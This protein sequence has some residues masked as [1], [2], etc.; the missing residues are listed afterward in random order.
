[1]ATC[2]GRKKDGTPCGSHIVLVNGYCRVHQDQATEEPIR[3]TRERL[4][5]AIAAHG[6]PEGLDLAD[7]DLSNFSRSQ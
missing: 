3:W 5:A 6:G 2:K 4:E 7:A 1:M